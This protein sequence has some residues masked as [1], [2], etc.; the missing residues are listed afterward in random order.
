MNDH[1]INVKDY[2][3]LTAEEIKLV[4]ENNKMIKRSKK[5]LEDQKEFDKKAKIDFIVE[6]VNTDKGHKVVT[7]D[8]K[9]NKRKIKREIEETGYAFALEIFKKSREEAIKLNFDTKEVQ[10]EIIIRT[11]IASIGDVFYMHRKSEYEEFKNLKNTLIKRFSK[12]MDQMISRL[13]WN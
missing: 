13:P 1:I 10:E 5:E 4:K 8:L 9:L 11:I 7:T 12:E 3:S 2:P 6:V